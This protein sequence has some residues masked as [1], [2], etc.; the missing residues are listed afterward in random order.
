MES[1]A[2]F[3]QGPVRGFSNLCRATGFMTRTRKSVGAPH[4]VY[5]FKCIVMIIYFVVI[6]KYKNQA[7]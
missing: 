5:T 6:T 2:V 1:I 3:T 4:V 7:S